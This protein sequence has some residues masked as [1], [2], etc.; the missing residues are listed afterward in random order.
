VSTVL[1]ANMTV[2]YLRPF[3]TVERTETVFGV[4]PS[5]AHGSAMSA[6]L[7]LPSG[8]EAQ[9]TGDRGALAAGRTHHMLPICAHKND[10]HIHTLIV[11][12]ISDIIQ[13]K[14]IHKITCTISDCIKPCV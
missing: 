4:Y 6:Q 3:M 1:H 2:P 9:Q 8:G 14:L 10:A 12:T 5:F 7:S 11:C 13:L